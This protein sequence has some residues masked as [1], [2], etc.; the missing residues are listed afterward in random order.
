MVVRPA[1]LMFTA[2]VKVRPAQYHDYSTHPIAKA[3][4]GPHHH[5]TALIYAAVAQLNILL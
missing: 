4:C 1:Q 2:W 5:M 3:V